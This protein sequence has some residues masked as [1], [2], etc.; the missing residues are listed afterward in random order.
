LKL[1]PGQ[2]ASAGVVVKNTA[3]TSGST[4]AITNNVFFTSILFMLLTSIKVKL[5]ATLAAFLYP[6]EYPVAAVGAKIALLL[7]LHPLLGSQLSPGWYGTHYHF[8]AYLNRKIIDELAGEISTL[9]TTLEALLF[10]A[11]FD[12]TIL[13]KNDRSL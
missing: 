1:L 4:R 5:I 13:A 10:G 6:S 11:G 9:M 8:L 7:F 12:G 3:I 2:P